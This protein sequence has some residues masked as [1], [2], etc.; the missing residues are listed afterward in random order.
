MKL[1]RVVMLA[2]LGVSAFSTASASEC[3]NDELTFNF[4]NI[5]TREA[6]AVLAD[7][8]GLRPQVDSSIESA[9]PLKFVCKPWRAAAEE[10]AAKYNLRLR[11]ENGVMSVSR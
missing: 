5:R 7:F 10:L 8:A 6:F 4:S 3:R 2:I 1:H 9:G 11:I